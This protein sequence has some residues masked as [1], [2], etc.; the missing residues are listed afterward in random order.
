MASDHTPASGRRATG[1][2]F[3]AGLLLAI[4]SMIGGCLS[5]PPS[6]ESAPSPVP[7]P[8]AAAPAQATPHE[9]PASAPGAPA[10][11][12]EGKASTGAAPGEMRPPGTDETRRDRPAAAAR[13]ASKRARGVAEQSAD[14]GLG[15]ASP[16]PQ[17]PAELRAQLERAERA[18]TPDCPS[19]RE[20]KKAVCDLAGQICRLTDRDPNVASVAEYCADAKQRCTDAERR[21]AQSCPD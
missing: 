14:D 8:P 2:V 20:R 9:A 15:G 13:A 6:R 19:A 18:A 11:A 1:L 12:T 4:P 16:E 3:C 10:T 7:P 21:T 5:P 17:K